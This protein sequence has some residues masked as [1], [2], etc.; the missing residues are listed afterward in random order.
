MTKDEDWAVL[1]PAACAST[2]SLML[3]VV[4]FSE[5][6]KPAM[7]GR[8][9]FLLGGFLGVRKDDLENNGIFASIEETRPLFITRV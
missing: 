6:S 5:S 2:S 4:K 8:D 3:S 9:L 1:S 7:L